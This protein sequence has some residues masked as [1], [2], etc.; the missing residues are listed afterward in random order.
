MRSFFQA[1]LVLVIWC[2]ASEALAQVGV[3]EVW[4][5]PDSGEF[6]ALPSDA[7]SAG[8]PPAIHVST[9]QGAS[10]IRLPGVPDGAGGELDITTF[11]AIPGAGGTDVLFAG[12][13]SDG[14]FRSVDAG[15]TWSAWNDA[16]I[17]IDRIS[18][19]SSAR[20][21]AWVVASDGSLY[22]SVDD[23]ANWTLVSGVSG[24]TVTAIVNSGGDMA[25]VGTDSGELI[26]L[27]DAGTMV[28]SLNG[29]SPFGG[30]ITALARTM[31]GTLY[32]GV[33]EGD[34][35]G[36]HVYRTDSPG[37]DTYVELEFDG[38]S[39]HLRGLAAAEDRV[40]LLDFIETAVVTGPGELLRYLITNDGGASFTDEYAPVMTMN[41][42]FAGPCDG[43][44]PWLLFAHD[45]G[46]HLKSRS[47]IGWTALAPVEEPF[48]PP[49]PPPPVTTGSDLSLQMVSPGPSVTS[50]SRG[51]RRYVL[52]VANYGPDDVSGLEVEVKFSTLSNTS[53]RIRP[54]QS[55]GESATIDGVDCERG[56]DSYSD[57]M[58]ICRLD[59]L[60]AN[61]RASIVL[62]QDLPDKCIRVNIDAEVDADNNSDPFADNGW[63]L[64]EI[65]VVDNAAAGGGGG[66]SG[67]GDGGGGG[68][69]A[70]GLLTLLGLL[71]ASRRASNDD[72]Q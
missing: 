53:S 1:L 54:V 63:L 66:P 30:P 58:L 26:E 70:F 65:A 55:W 33:D 6:Y 13:E 7:D 17:G 2:V 45:E 68:G 71:L 18:V 59:S 21:A 14:L 43:C 47:G 52:E 38:S 10:W 36:A 42:L 61:G 72:T 37:L 56:S 11:A 22:V 50:I 67:G 46:L 15:T 62:I 27:S 23:G 31:D 60:A 4:R 64:H 16:A 5:H 19:A 35:N 48:T 20:E 49:P 24:R 40:Y 32:L 8:R 44:E 9:D 57:P 69:G 28:T 34:A 29:A 39:L 3:S 41:Q 12:T 51:T 25:W